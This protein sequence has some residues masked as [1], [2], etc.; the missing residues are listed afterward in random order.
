[1][2]EPGETG[3]TEPSEPHSQLSDEMREMIAGR[4]TAMSVPGT[5][6]VRLSPAIAPTQEMR[7]QAIDEIRALAREAKPLPEGVTIKDLLAEGR[8]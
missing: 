4:E 3:I 6:A 8:V 1:M 7:R 5:R 2:R